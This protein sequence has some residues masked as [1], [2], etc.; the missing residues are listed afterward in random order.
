MNILCRAISHRFVSLNS[1]Q[2]SL[3]HHFVSSA[4]CSPLTRR[5]AHYLTQANPIHQPGDLVTGILKNIVHHDEEV[6]VFNK[7]P[8]VKVLGKA[9]P[10]LALH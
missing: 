8:G 4:R 10:L 7:P 3:T 1:R 5:F 2:I 9:H 6:I